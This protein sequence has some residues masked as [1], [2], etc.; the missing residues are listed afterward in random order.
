MRRVTAA[1]TAIALLAT[2]C[3]GVRTIDVIDSGSGFA[4]V[5]SALADRSGRVVLTNGGEVEAT[6]IVLAADSTRMFVTAP[7][8]QYVTIPTARIDKIVVTQRLQG[9][10]RG[11][12]K[13]FLIGFGTGIVFASA[14]YEDDDNL[15]S[16]SRSESS[17]LFGTLFGAFG[18]ILGAGAGAYFGEK[19]VYDLRS[20]RPPHE[21]PD[22]SR[23]SEEEGD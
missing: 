4:E 13:G 11:G 2:G 16:L 18:L 23:P 8:P 3:A 6:H 14:A 21:T 10:M 19:D 1:V 20:V 15:I 7:L 17:I 12:A 9:A 22:T 5:N